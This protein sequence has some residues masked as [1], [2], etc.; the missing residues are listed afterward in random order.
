MA[1]NRGKEMALKHAFTIIEKSSNR[2]YLYDADVYDYYEQGML[3]K[4]YSIYIK[5]EFLQNLL[6]DNLGNSRSNLRFSE[7]GIDI[8]EQKDILEW[9]DFLNDSKNAKKQRDKNYQDMY[10]FMRDA[11]EEQGYVIHF[12][13]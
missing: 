8:Y 5:D 7:W 1:N 6:Y 12:G 10:L 11:K 4:I 13:I 2:E 9:I 3:K